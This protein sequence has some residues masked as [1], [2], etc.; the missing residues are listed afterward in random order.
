MNERE[1]MFEVYHVGIPYTNEDEN[2]ACIAVAFAWEWDEFPVITDGECHPG[3]IIF[4]PAGLEHAQAFGEKFVPALNAE[5]VQY[6]FEPTYRGGGRIYYHDLD[7][8]NDLPSKHELFKYLY[9]RKEITKEEFKITDRATLA[10]KAKASNGRWFEFNT[11]GKLV[12][13]R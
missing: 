12:T 11:A 5:L 7:D 3:H 1:K 13:I 2:R 6:G 10:A 9:S 8:L 4:K